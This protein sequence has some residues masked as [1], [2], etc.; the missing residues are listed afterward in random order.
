MSGFFHRLKPDDFRLLSAYGPIE[1][2]NIAD[3]PISYEDLEPYYTKVERVVGV[4]GRVADHPHAEPRSTADY[5][6]PPTL[7]HPISHWID[8][9]CEEL[10]LH[11]VPVPRAVLPRADMGRQGCSYTGY[12]GSYGC[13]TGAKGGSRAALLSRAVAT[14]RCEVSPHAMVSRLVSDRKG[15]VVAAQYYDA[16]NKLQNVDARIYVVA[17][18]AI[19]TA[20]LL[21]RSTGPRHEHGLANG[22]GMVGRNLLFSAGGSGTGD[23]HYANLEKHKAEQLRFRGPFVNRALYDW[24]QIGEKVLGRRSKGGMLEF[25]FKHP[26]AIARANAQKW[27]P[28]G[29]IWGQPLKERVK[30][31]FT[32]A[33]YLSFE[34]FCD[35][36][37]NDDCFVSLDPRERDRW[38]MSVARVRIGYH[39]HDLIVGKYLAERGEEVLSWMGAEN[40]RSGVSG[41]PPANLVAGGCR[42]GTDPK[43]SVLNSN[44]RA[45]DVEN[46]YVSD[47]SFMP[48]GGSVPYTWTIYANAFRV[49]D[50]IVAELGGP[51]KT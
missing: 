7:E 1:G 22:N 34:A 33:R 9:A 4:S 46:L 21:L 23:F 8:E 30:S 24:Y 51:R 10:E 2:A 12:C 40:V 37:P 38:G 43:T 5:P 41:D 20:R 45:H 18:Q 6:Y 32:Q 13:S 31:Y 50:G 26:N 19:E 27:G 15:R 35:W 28:D 17:C 3:W 11:A 36:L 39:P 25:L 29:L 47:G 49:G 16:Q 44:C 42:F 14:G 48:T